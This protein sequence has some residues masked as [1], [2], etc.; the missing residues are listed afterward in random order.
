MKDKKNEG[1]CE[2]SAIFR[3]LGH[4]FQL[5]PRLLQT[6]LVVWFYKN[7]GFKPQLRLPENWWLKFFETPA[8]GMRTTFS[9]QTLGVEEGVPL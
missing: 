7:Q 5:L 3:R 2:A 8:S 9:C 1:G 4:P 6:A